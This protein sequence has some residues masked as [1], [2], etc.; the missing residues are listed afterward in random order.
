MN[1]NPII[2]LKNIIK[3]FVGVPV[4]ENVSFNIYTKTVHGL[5]GGNGAGKSTLMNILSGVYQPDSGEI[6]I[7][8]NKERL[9]SPA[10]AH[11][12]G[13]YLVPQAPSLFPYLTIEEN[14][15]LGMNVKKS[16][17]REKIKT[18]M[19][20]LSC[21]FTLDQIG[22][23]LS[24]AKQQLVELIKGL[25]RESDVIILD[26]PT[27]AL[28]SREVD[29]LFKTIK[30]LKD[31]KNIGFVYITHRLQELFDIVDK[32]TILKNGEIVSEGLIEN[33]T[34]KNIIQTM[35]PKI[36]ENDVAKIE[37]TIE[38]INEEIEKKSTI[39]KLKTQKFKNKYVLEVEN[40]AGEGF[41]NVSL[42][43]R[44][45][46]ILVLTGVVGAG[47]TEFVETLFGIRKKLSGK[48]S[49]DGREINIKQ[50]REAIKQGIVYLP[51]DRHLHGVFMKASIKENISSS[52]LFKIFKF[53]LIEKKEKKLAID[54]IKSLNIVSTGADQKIMYLSGGNRQKVALGKWLAAIP[55]VLILDEPTRGID[56][57]ARKEIYVSIK[58]L[59]EEG[60]SI[61]LVSSDFEEVVTLSE[62]VAVIYRG[63]TVE[64]ISPPNITLENIT[65]ASFG[66]R[67]INEK[68]SYKYST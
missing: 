19:K 34:L 68:K 57:N 28:T 42:K 49:L 63:R 48:I 38:K 54:F 47:R 64:D 8:R 29:A 21:D 13:I 33:Y 43:L 41:F 4:L 18:L 30:Q 27:S 25:I 12:K 1:E 32:L 60:V 26:E 16:E 45:G 35:V 56:A 40:L 59:A 52:I 67:G 15:L 10:D 61:L 46:E 37:I 36:S 5:V 6:W 66:Y 3:V 44:K 50:P 58:K 39:K 31:E 9:K 51:E 20:A 23:D 55:K 17:Y 2:E 65:F 14:I 7:K 22:A 11:A 62:K 24:I 53:F